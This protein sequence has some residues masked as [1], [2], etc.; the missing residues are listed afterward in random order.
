MTKEVAR[1]VTHIVATVVEIVAKI[2]PAR[3]AKLAPPPPLATRAP[4]GE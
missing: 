4:S 1:R 3:G 2:A